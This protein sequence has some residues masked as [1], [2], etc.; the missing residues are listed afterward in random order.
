MKK[1]QLRLASFC[2]AG[3]QTAEQYGTWL[4]SQ[5]SC[6]TPFGAQVGSAAKEVCHEHLIEGRQVARVFSYLRG[7]TFVAGGRDIRPSPHGVP[8]AMMFGVA[9]P[10]EG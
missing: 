5:C 8:V 2:V 1:Q 6:S 4:M 3:L 7:L 9:T 10:E